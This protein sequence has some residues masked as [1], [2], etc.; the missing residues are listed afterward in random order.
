MDFTKSGTDALGT[1]RHP[2]K[3]Q[4]H[5]GSVLM[6]LV[7]VGLLCF[8][9]LGLS[10]SE[11]FKFNI[12]STVQK[13]D[14]MEAFNVANAGV[15][16][17]LA[18]IMVPRNNRLNFM[19]DATEAMFSNSG[20]MYTDNV[21]QTGLIGIYR[22][23]VLGGDPARDPNS[24]QYM[25]TE[26]SQ[27]LNMYSK[28]RYFV[29]SRGTVCQDTN[30]K[31]LSDAFNLS[32]LIPTCTRGT[33]RN[34]SLVSEVDMTAFAAGLTGMAASGKLG[35][36]ESG[37]RNGVKVFR[38]FNAD[39]PVRL[40]KPAFVPGLSGSE[41]TPVTQFDFDTAWVHSTPS[42][43]APT[44]L[45][46]YNFI[47]RTGGSSG[48]TSSGGSSGGGITS[49]GT[50]GGKGGTSSP[51]TPINVL[52]NALPDARLETYA[53]PGGVAMPG[54]GVMRLFFRQ[55]IDPRTLYRDTPQDCLKGTSTCRIRVRENIGGAWVNAKFNVTPL[56]P[57]LSQVL[58]FVTSKGGAGY[59]LS[60]DGGANGVKDF[61]GEP[62]YD[63]A[64]RLY[65]CIDSTK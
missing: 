26:S 29:V 64:K 9:A 20:R 37:T 1:I 30:G 18:T 50:S 32:S 10:L 35:G 25:G 45:A 12:W 54:T 47:S 53:C 7:V 24:G 44:F 13:V 52:V 33:D 8:V 40:S 28:Q 11:T 31:I 62:A 17:A 14:S 15:N 46:T 56:Y 2:F 60:V 39:D 42:A 57:S 51:L 43:S 55:S 49:G 61:S 4:A 36:S 23:M 6:A 58:I 22:Y 63:S 48:G 3:A 19:G 41:R 27:F 38:I 59:E 5:R 16:E 65:L 34:V 21:H